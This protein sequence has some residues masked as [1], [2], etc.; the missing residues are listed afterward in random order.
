MRVAM[1]LVG[2][3]WYGQVRAPG[4]PSMSSTPPL[5]L[6]VDDDEDSR[7]LYSQSLQSAGGYRL[8]EAG[9]GQRAIEHASEQLPDVIVMDLS[10]PVLDGS[11]AMRA[12]RADAKTRAIPI[13][14]LTGYGDVRASKEPNAGFQAV[15][16]KPCLPE[17]LVR[18]IESVLESRRREDDRE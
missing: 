9:D 1:A 7:Y 18:T 15:L 12:I 2:L 5:V 10:L 6:L 13:I 11:G 14:A 4:S 8:A 17:A 16:V 3:S